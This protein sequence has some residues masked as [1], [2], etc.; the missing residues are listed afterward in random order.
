[1]LY[2]QRPLLVQELQ[3]ALATFDESQNAKD[4]ELDDPDVIFGACANLV[5]EQEDAGGWI[6]QNT[7]RLIHY[8]VQEYFASDD[9]PS[10]SPSI[11]SAIGS[12]ADAN[13]SL[14]ADCLAHFYQP[15]MLSGQFDP[16]DHPGCWL[17]QDAFLYYAARCFDVHLLATDPK[18]ARR[19]IDDLLDSRPELFRS[20]LDIRILYRYEWLGWITKE[21]PDLA[22]AGLLERTSV[23]EKW[24]ASSFVYATDLLL[25]PGLEREYHSQ[26]GV[27]SA[28]FF[29]IGDGSVEKARQLLAAGADVNCC[30][31]DGN[32]PLYYAA[33]NTDLTLLLIQ[34][35]ADFMAQS[36]NGGITLQRAARNGGPELI[37]AL[38][39]AGADA[40]RGNPLVSAAE[41]S[42]MEN[43]RCLVEAGADVNA[44]GSGDKSALH[45][46]SYNA[47]FE[48]VAYLLANGADI[49]LKCGFHGSP[50]CA[51]LAG[52]EISCAHD[53]FL[54]LL[55]RGALVDVEA[56]MSA[57]KNLRV[58]EMSKILLEL[59]KGPDYSASNIRT[60][61]IEVGKHL[62]ASWTRDKKKVATRLLEMRLSR[63]GKGSKLAKGPDIRALTTS[64]YE[65][66]CEWVGDREW[67]SDNESESER[68]GTS[69]S[70]LGGY[71]SN[72]RL[73]QKQGRPVPGRHRTRRV[74]VWFIKKR[75]DAKVMLRLHEHG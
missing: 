21:R 7:V 11:K 37:R 49:N 45:A 16:I 17:S 15:M 72:R 42:N 13:A 53:V 9:Q 30:D 73:H 56:L 58:R 51:S 29:G 69:G 60:A 62:D 61:L 1:M 18:I 31:F 8:S 6:N 10:L 36:R 3:Y 70:E 14:A 74:Y 34:K 48:L 65:A 32:S 2:A 66:E 54:L 63:S 25:L 55:R 26:E 50:L 52:F 71:G 44:T 38:L 47:E 33:W 12:R 19:Y 35:G 75:R 28:L 22:D 40:N 4:F 24:T 27:N 68:S 39:E 41:V 67:E 46:A 20:I 59:D 64:I 43:V 23:I 57:A 5:V